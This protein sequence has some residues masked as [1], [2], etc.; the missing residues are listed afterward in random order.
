MASIQVKD[1]NLEAHLQ[2][3]EFFD[4]DRHPDL[5]FASKSIA[6][7]DGQLTI[8]GTITMKGHTEDVEIKGRISDPIADPYGRRTLRPEA[9]GRGRPR[10][11]RHQLEQPAAE[12]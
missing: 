3:P 12:R 6:R 7:E 1:P 10:Q 4:V 11:V 8:E 2:G 5:T 9:R